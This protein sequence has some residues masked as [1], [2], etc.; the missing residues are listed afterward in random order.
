MD[1][2]WPS[3]P[4][5]HVYPVSCPPCAQLKLLSLIILALSL[6]GAAEATLRG[7]HFSPTVRAVH[8]A[9][10]G[11][12]FFS[13]LAL[14]VR[15][16][17]D[18]VDSHADTVALAVGTPLFAAAA[19]LA[20]WL[21]W[22]R[23]LRAAAKII[24]ETRAAAGL[25]AGITAAAMR[26]DFVFESAEQVHRVAALLARSTVGLDS[27]PPD[28][29]FAVEATFLSGIRAFPDTALLHVLLARFK[30]DLADASFKVSSVAGGSGGGGAAGG[31][32][33]DGIGDAS[34]VLPP[35]PQASVTHV[36][37]AKG[38]SAPWRVRFLVYSA[39]AELRLLTRADAAS[40]EE[41]ALDL[42]GY[43]E[44]QSEL[45]A[46]FRAHRAALAANRRFW[47]LLVHDSISFRAVAGSF[48]DM[49]ACEAAAEK[50]YR[51]ALEK[52]PL[53][54]KLT[55]AFARFI[56]EVLK[57][58]MRAG[59]MRA[60]AER[61]EHAAEANARKNT[62]EQGAVNEKVDAIV[63]CGSNGI[64]KIA[65]RNLHRLFGYRKDELLGKNVSVL[66]VR[67]ARHSRHRSDRTALLL[68]AADHS[69]RS[70]TPA[71]PSVQPAAQRVHQALPR[72]A[73]AHDPGRGAAPRGQAQAGPPVPDQHHR[74]QDR[75]RRRR[76][77]H[78]A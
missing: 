75:V 77:L 76:Q 31:A 60:E 67:D 37:R 63:V 58:P 73:E 12:T 42:Q 46:C 22:R 78:G 72:H 11:G 41:S 2:K 19:A 48:R 20:S 30:M 70:A 59:K 5:P 26:L 51:T 33:P 43:V 32:G 14:V 4:S 1:G 57:D 47:R 66:M 65:N 61:L 64:I 3:S 56:E 50:A 34:R 40:T 52:R 6:A 39:D 44:L 18:P 15:V 27:V 13:S 68:A 49:S 55:R 53:N 38:L 23:D 24:A 69:P 8:A 62:A 35:V 36:E 74:Q 29:D 45:Q 54:V 9:C 28:I 16:H 71:G 21:L 7:T 17:H 25:D 10:A